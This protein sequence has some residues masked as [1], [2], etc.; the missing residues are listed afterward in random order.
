M[1][2]ICA[3]LRHQVL[4]TAADLKVVLFSQADQPDRGS[5]GG[6]LAEVIRLKHLQPSQRAWDLLSVALSAIAA[7]TGVSRSSSSDGW[8]RDIDLTIAVQD[9]AFWTSQQKLLES[10]LRFLTTDRW[11][12]SFVGDGAG[13]PVPLTPREP[14]ADS[15]VLLSGGL[16]SLVGAIDLT[17]RQSMKPF[18][19]S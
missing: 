8:T 19:V 15:V 13:P 14:D 18:A 5:A 11:N 9:A 2:L 10:A 16:D 12:V 6:A 17:T 4:K 3:P 7:D 1:K